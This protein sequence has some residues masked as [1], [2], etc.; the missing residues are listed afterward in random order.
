[1]NTHASGVGLTEDVKAGVV[2]RF[3]SLPIGRSAVLI[4]RTGADLVTNAVT[5]LVMLLIGFVVGFTPT[6]PVYQVALAV[7]LVLAFAYVFSWISAFI[8]FSVRDPETVQSVGFIWVFPLVFAS[9]A[10]VPT[11]SMPRVVHAFVNINPVSLTVNAARALTIGHG[12]ALAPTL[13]TLAWLTGLL[14]LFVPCPSE[15]FAARR[16]SVPGFGD[17]ER[18]ADDVPRF[19]A[20]MP[21]RRP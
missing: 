1:M 16:R 3:R 21:R 20:S 2:D 5:L 17:Q 9:S 8:G 7:A 19:D 14:L 4:G 11:A 12:H 10:F 13:G 6:Q 18:L 15:R